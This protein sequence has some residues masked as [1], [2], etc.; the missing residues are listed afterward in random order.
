M[1]HAAHAADADTW[2]Y[3][4][5]NVVV[6]AIS[7]HTHVPSVTGQEWMSMAI[8]ALNVVVLAI[9]HLSVTGVMVGKESTLCALIAGNHPVKVTE[10]SH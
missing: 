2:K 8:H 7:P 1:I 9:L 3:T 10:S 4:V 6:T 5:R